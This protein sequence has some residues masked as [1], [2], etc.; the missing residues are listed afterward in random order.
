MQSIIAPWIYNLTNFFESQ[1]TRLMTLNIKLAT[2]ISAFAAAIFLADGA[3]ARSVETDYN[4]GVRAYQREDYV[5]ARIHWEKAK[6]DRVRAAHNNLGCLLYYGMGGTADPS[7]AVAL[8]PVAARNGE[9][10]S[11]WHLAATFEEGKG[12]STDLLTAYAWYRCAAVNFADAPADVADEYALRNAR[13][14]IARIIPKLTL[15]HGAGWPE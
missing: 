1:L 3:V 9:R 13:A 8:W 4:L 2:I 12:V 14:A 11:Q 6:Q 15:L 10:E 7:R 5:T